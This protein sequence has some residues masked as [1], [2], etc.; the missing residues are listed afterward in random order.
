METMFSSTRLLVLLASKSRIRRYGI[1]VISV[2]PSIKET[3]KFPPLPVNISLPELP[4]T[5]LVYVA[6]RRLVFV[7][8]ST[9]AVSRSTDESKGRKVVASR[10]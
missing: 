9:S 3:S 2:S 10:K 4:S 8:C 7:S 6:S 5:K 1:V